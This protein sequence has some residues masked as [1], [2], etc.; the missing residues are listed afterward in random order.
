MKHYAAAFIA[1]V[2]MISILAATPAEK[3]AEA[4]ARQY[5]EAADKGNVTA[6]YA[7]LPKSY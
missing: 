3:S 2:P 7:M 1:M 6:A 4:A 5:V